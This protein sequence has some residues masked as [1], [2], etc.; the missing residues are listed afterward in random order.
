MEERFTQFENCDFLRPA[1][2][3]CLPFLSLCLIIDQEVPLI[4]LGE[5]AKFLSHPEYM[6]NEQIKIIFF[7][8]KAA[9][10]L[11]NFIYCGSQKVS[12]GIA[13]HSVKITAIFPPNSFVEGDL[14]LKVSPETN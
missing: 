5:K 14:N 9:S 8:V 10:K 4:P 6:V 12:K 2:I 11:G 7:S 3:H 13:Q 1:G